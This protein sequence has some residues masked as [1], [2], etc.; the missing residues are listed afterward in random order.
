MIEELVVDEIRG[1][2]GMEYV[3]ATHPF[4]SYS[5]RIVEVTFTAALGTYRVGD[6][7]VVDVSRLIDESTLP[8]PDAVTPGA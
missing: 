8:T 4:S 5:Q 6:H 7:V 3:R 1:D 2:S